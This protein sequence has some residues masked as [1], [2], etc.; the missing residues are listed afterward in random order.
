MKNIR[1]IL[2]NLSYGQTKNIFMAHL[3]WALENKRYSGEPVWYDAEGTLNVIGI[4]CNTE[5]D[6]NFGKYNDFLIL[7][8]NKPLDK[9][10]QEIINVTVDPGRNKENIAHLRQGVWDSYV[11]RPH[12]HDTRYFAELSKTI[13]RWAICQDQNTVM[14]AR[15]NG[16]GTVIEN[17]TGRFGINI[18]DSGGYR[19]SSLGC[20]V[21]Q[22]DSDYLEKLLPYLYD[23]K[24]EKK[25]PINAGNIT[26][27]LINHSQLEKYVEET[28]EREVRAD[29]VNGVEGD[30][31]G[32]AKGGTKEGTKE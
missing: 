8:Y 20:T 23:L 31:S 16:K 5:A 2:N 6:F 25:V 21:I 29:A 10:D 14:V 17:E 12:R 28:I 26:Y 30:T 7:V 4:R 22:K 11:I 13:A 27:C 3:K 18:H 15:T 19:D 24:A 32:G 1:E 9:Y